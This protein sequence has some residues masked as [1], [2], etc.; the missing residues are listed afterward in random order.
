MKNTEIKLNLKMLKVGSE[1]FEQLDINTQNYL[2]EKIIETYDLIHDQETKNKKES[3]L[4]KK[5][6][7][8]NWINNKWII[9]S[10]LFVRNQNKK[11]LCY[12]PEHNIFKEGWI[13]DFTRDIVQ[14]TTNRKQL[15]YIC[16]L[17]LSTELYKLLDLNYEYANQVY[18][19]TNYLTREEYAI[20]QGYREGSYLEVE[21]IL[22]KFDFLLSNDYNKC[23]QARRNQNLAYLIAT[24]YMIL[25]K[26]GVI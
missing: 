9:V 10:I 16:N 23:G 6:E 7:I 5:Y 22:K 3:R 4:S 13:W 18:F 14:P 17:K 1:V 26:K 2:K 20:I 8:G 12:N 24:T 21:H 19:K 15:C 11:I 25:I